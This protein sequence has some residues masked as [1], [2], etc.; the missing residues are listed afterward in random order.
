MTKIIFFRLISGWWNLK[1]CWITWRNFKSI[2]L[3]ILCYLCRNIL[4]LRQNYSINLD[5]KT[6]LST[7]VVESF[8]FGTN[9][10]HGSSRA[11]DTL[12]TLSTW[13]DKW[14]LKSD[15]R[16]SLILS[17]IFSTWSRKHKLFHMHNFFLMKKIY[18]KPLMF[19]FDMFFT[20]WNLFFNFTVSL[21]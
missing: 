9:A 2:F 1:H 21:Y 16:E 15:V 14:I 10:F 3:T 20:K 7:V 12:E 13:R 11:D 18:Q 19:S 8:S 6:Y 17:M 4:F 5:L